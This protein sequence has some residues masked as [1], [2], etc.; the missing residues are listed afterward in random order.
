MTGEPD[1]N[2]IIPHQNIEIIS[3]IPQSYIKPNLIL[4]DYILFKLHS[5]HSNGFPEYGLKLKPSHW[6]YLYWQSFAL[7]ER[8]IY[9][10]LQVPLVTKLSYKVGS[11]WL[12]SNFHRN[13]WIVSWLSKIWSPNFPSALRIWCL[14]NRTENFHT[15][16]CT[17]IQ[18]RTRQYNS[19]V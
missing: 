1:W 15:W 10:L 9:I 6:K 3:V 7:Y 11:L 5:C 2:M 17:T 8:R 14:T 13:N 18:D 19:N 12:C 16:H 4:E